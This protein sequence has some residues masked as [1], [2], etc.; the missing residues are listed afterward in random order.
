[1]LIVYFLSELYMNRLKAE[2]NLL[3]ALKIYSILFPQNGISLS[4][5]SDAKGHVVDYQFQFS[6]K[7]LA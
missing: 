7:D 5:R 3:P 1:M 2:K 6:S 4:S